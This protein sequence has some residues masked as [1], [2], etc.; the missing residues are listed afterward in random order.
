MIEVRTAT[1]VLHDGRRG[2]W[3]LVTAGS[4]RNREVTFRTQRSGGG[5]EAEKGEPG[6]EDGSGPEAAAYGRSVLHDA[7]TRCLPGLVDEDATDESLSGLK[8][9]ECAS[10]TACDGSGHI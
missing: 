5:R 2:A 3:P 10:C 1:P 6:D 7:R 8:R 4:L 9:R